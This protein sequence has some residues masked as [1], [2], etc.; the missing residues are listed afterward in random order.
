M[1]ILYKFFDKTNLD[2]N[3]VKIPPHCKFSIWTESI[4][5][6]TEVITK[7]TESDVDVNSKCGAGTVFDDA[8]NTCLLEGT[9][10]TSKCGAG[11][12][13]DDATNTCLLK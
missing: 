10:T 1:I 4:L 3:C 9:Q 12:V 8:T 13:F 2:V 7:T 11:T 6:P 5:P